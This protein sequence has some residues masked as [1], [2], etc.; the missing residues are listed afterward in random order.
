MQIP[1]QVKPAAWGA[2]AGAV[3]LAIIGFSWGGW[4][5]G[6]TAEKMAKAGADTAVV[7]ALAPI[8]V[9]QFQL[10]PEASAK[11]LE[12]KNIQTYGRGAYIEKA[13]WATMPKGGSPNSG[14]ARACAAMLTALNP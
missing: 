12:L 9:E 5:T 6:G 13:G 4:V 14:V 3:A 11:L 8:C 10:Q 7:A 1:S 2:I